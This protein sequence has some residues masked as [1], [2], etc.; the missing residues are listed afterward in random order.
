MLPSGAPRH[1]AGGGRGQYSQADVG[2]FSGQ[3]AGA[4][5]RTPGPPEV[6]L[7]APDLGGRVPEAGEAGV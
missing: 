6:E 4:V 5:S 2:D 1:R 3:G 7:L